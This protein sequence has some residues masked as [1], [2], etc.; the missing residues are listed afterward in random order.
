MTSWCGGCS[1]DVS[2]ADSLF[3]SCSSL[4][5]EFSMNMESSCYNNLSSM[6]DSI[7]TQAF[8]TYGNSCEYYVLSYSTSKDPIFGEDD[9]RSILRK[10]PFKAYFELPKEENIYAKFG[11]EDM[12]NFHMYIS[13]NHFASASRLASSATSLYVSAHEPVYGS[14]EPKVGDLVK[15]ESN[16]R[17][18]E[19]V[20]IVKEEERFLNREH[21]YDIIVRKFI[22]KSYG[23]SP[24][25]SADMIDIS[26]VNDIDDIFD[27]TDLIDLSATSTTNYIPVSGET[28]S[29]QDN[30][31]GWFD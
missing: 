20:N 8:N 3:G 7:L 19:I 31:K 12:N 4:P 10:F 16:C 13:M 26:A 18:Y 15:V 22:D 9:N 28:S 30:L 27:I 2:G 11:I 6:Y 24:S 25:T 23:Y 29:E 21:T 17:F 1:S 5:N 14:Y